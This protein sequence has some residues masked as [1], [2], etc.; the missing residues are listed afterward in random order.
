MIN[1]TR[2]KRMGSLHYLGYSHRRH[3]FCLIFLSLPLRIEIQT[4]EPPIYS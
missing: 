2:E 1:R 3:R 4:V